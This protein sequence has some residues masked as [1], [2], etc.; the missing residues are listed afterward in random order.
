MG[1]IDR[2]MGIIDNIK[3]AFRYD[4]KDEKRAKIAPTNKSKLFK[5]KD[6]PKKVSEMSNYDKTFHFFE[7][8]ALWL[9]KHGY[10]LKVHLGNDEKREKPKT[11]FRA[12]IDKL[13]KLRAKDKVL[14]K[15]TITRVNK[16]GIKV[17][18]YPDL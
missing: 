16:Y 9:A 17:Q 10:E 12:M 14:S 18:R 13:H 15:V 3:E 8:R 7:Q 6:E 4:T 11:H 1:I 5:R 2:F